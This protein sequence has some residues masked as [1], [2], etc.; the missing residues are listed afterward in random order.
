M[1]VTNKLDK[2]SDDTN[3]GDHLLRCWLIL[4]SATFLL[5]AL[6]ANRDAQ[7]QDSGFFILRA[8]AGEMHNPFGLAPTHPLHYW[9][10][11]FMVKLDFWQPS[12]A[13]TLISSL[14]AAVTIS[15]LFGCVHAITHSFKSAMFAAISLAFAHTFWKL[16]TVA[17]VY[18]LTTAL[19]SAELWCLIIFLHTKQRRFLLG[20]CLF[21]GLGIANNL[22]ALLNVPILAVIILQLLRR[23][24][25]LARDLLAGFGLWVLGTAPYTILVLQALATSGDFGGTIHSAFFGTAFA[26]KVL[27]IWPGW[28][29]L[30]ICFAFIGL[31]FPNL[32]IPLSL[33]GIRKAIGHSQMRWTTWIIACFLFIHALFALR[34]PVVDQHLFLLPAYMYLVILGGIGFS[35]LTKSQREKLVRIILGFAWTLA[36]ITPAIVAFAPTIA[37]KA[38][39]LAKVER[40]KP[41]RDDYIYLFAP[42]SVVD[43]SA[44]KMSAHAIELAEPNG[45]ILV[46]DNMASYA[47]QY[48]VLQE[49]LEKVSVLVEPQDDAIRTATESERTIVLVPL[50]LTV[51]PPPVP[52][53]HWKRIGDLYVLE[54]EPG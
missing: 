3:S 4:L 21:N 8:T 13:V 32:L 1:M 40:H 19:M 28:N 35:I 26:G 31:C 50:N 46:E 37:R 14:A 16:A 11:R 22:A 48:K 38:N 36:F 7:W 17:E 30:I 15:N 9:L 33:I 12:F 6:T 27:S 29:R 34:Y 53:G 10:S 20:V 42:W 45:I 51:P 25:V 18:T 49:G 52:M 44:E 23:K 39:V 24:D 43:D 2:S 41:Y 47:I 5:Y 54:R